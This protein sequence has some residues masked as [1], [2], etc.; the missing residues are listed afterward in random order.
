VGIEGGQLY[1]CHSGLSYWLTHHL[2]PSLAPT[3]HR[4]CRRLRVDVL[5]D[6]MHRNDENGW[7]VGLM[8]G[9][10]ELH[11]WWVNCFGFHGWIVC[12]LKDLFRAYVVSLCDVC[13]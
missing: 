9:S 3:I 12:G 10:V 6:A 5:Q 4:S 7:W 1:H 2:P 13:G 11:S 8:P